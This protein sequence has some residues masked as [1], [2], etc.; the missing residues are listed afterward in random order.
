YEAL[1]QLSQKYPGK[2]AVI[3]FPSNDFQNQ[4]KVTDK[5]I[6]QFCKINYGVTFPLMKKSSV[7]KS[8]GQ[9]QVYQWLTDAGKNGWNSKPPEW[10]F[11]KYLIDENGKLV[12]YF[13]PGMSPTDAAV[14]KAI[15][16]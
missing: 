6:A 16:N 4:E 5:S 10:N 15:E 8:S 14:L 9:N 11:T 12:N 3:G 2:L 7:K 1:E 13:P